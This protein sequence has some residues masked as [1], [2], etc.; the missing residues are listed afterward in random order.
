[1][2]AL[3]IFLLILTSIQCLLGSFTLGVIV[4]RKQSIILFLLVAIVVMLS[5]A[6][7]SIVLKTMIR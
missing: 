4:S 1:M 3:K 7:F 5:A 2:T 6:N